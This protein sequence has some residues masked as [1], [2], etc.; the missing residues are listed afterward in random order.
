MKMIDNG[1]EMNAEE[2]AQFYSNTIDIV[3]EMVYCHGDHMI[4]DVTAVTS[5]HRLVL[6]MD[7][8]CGTELY[9][10]IYSTVTATH[11][12]NGYSIRIVQ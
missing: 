10:P 7:L 9:S 11:C 5:D 12:L 8:P 3:T 4:G 2:F 1:F 6:D